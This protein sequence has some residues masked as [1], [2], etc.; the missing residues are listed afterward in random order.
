MKASRCICEALSQGAISGKGEMLVS[1]FPQVDAKRRL[2]LSRAI[3]FIHFPVTWPNSIKN[4]ILSSTV[5]GGELHRLGLKFNFCNLNLS[6][7]ARGDPPQTPIKSIEAE[8]K[9]I[10]AKPSWTSTRSRWT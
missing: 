9:S 5:I 8:L 7:V 4:F 2:K 6:G 1:S 3:I 10:E